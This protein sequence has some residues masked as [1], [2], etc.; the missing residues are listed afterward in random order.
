MA[1]APARIGNCRRFTR[2]SAAA[3]YRWFRR[4]CL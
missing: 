1:A 2:G 4:I 3:I